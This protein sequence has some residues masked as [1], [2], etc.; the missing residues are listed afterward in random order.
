MPIVDLAPLVPGTSQAPS[1]LAAIVGSFDPL[2][3]GHQWMVEQLLERFEAVAL[4][5]PT[6]HFEKSVRFPENATLPQRLELIERAYRAAPARHRL[7]AGLTGELLFLRLAGLL[8]QRFVGARI[9]F[10]MGGDTYRKLLA[11]PRYYARLGLRWGERQ[12]RALD[13]LSREVVVFDRG[14]QLWPGA[15]PAPPEL[16]HLSSTRVRQLAG[17]LHAAGASATAWERE[18][19]PLVAPQVIGYIRERGLYRPA[20]PVSP[21]RRRQESLLH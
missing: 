4:L 17:R 9:G 10:G 12:R 3:R 13:A 21:P 19:G 1:S 20:T 14:C 2:H 18:L 6:W 11:S 5:I 15:V 16:Q 7:S 8:Q